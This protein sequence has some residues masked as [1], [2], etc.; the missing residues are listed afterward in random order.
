LAKATKT[1]SIKTSTSY[2]QIIEEERRIQI[3][4]EERRRVLMEVCME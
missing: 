2:N 3:I 1:I 4:E